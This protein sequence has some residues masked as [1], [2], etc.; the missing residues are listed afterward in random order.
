MQSF[1]CAT[2]LLIGQSI[3][4]H[5]FTGVGRQEPYRGSRTY[6]EGGW[7]HIIKGDRNTGGQEHRGTGT[8]NTG[9]KHCKHMMEGMGTTK[10][11]KTNSVV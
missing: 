5:L 10:D 6:D 4:F 9:G 11:I 2:L 8:Q 3:L 1:L 7:G